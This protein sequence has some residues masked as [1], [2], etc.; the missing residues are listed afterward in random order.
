MIAV[1]TLFTTKCGHPT[2]D[3]Q[4]LGAVAY[5]GGVGF[6]SGARSG[7]GIAPNGAELH[8]VTDFRPVAGC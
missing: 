7:R 3:W 2:G 8:P 1:W 4:P 5:V 6:W